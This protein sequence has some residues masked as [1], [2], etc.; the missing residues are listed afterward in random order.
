MDKL[1]S[2][3]APQYVDGLFVPSV[4]IPVS[5]PLTE[6]TVWDMLPTALAVARNP[7]E[8]FNAAQYKIPVS[9][10]PL[11]GVFFT[12]VNHPNMIRHCFVENRGNYGFQA[13]RQRVL[14]AIIGDGLI[15]AEGETWQHARR[16]MA[17]MFTPRAIKGFGQ[18]M[19]AATKRE[20]PDLFDTD[21]VMPIAPAMA[22]LILN[23]LLSIGDA[24]TAA[25][26]DTQIE[27]HLLAF[28]G[29]GHETTARALSWMFYLLS[30]DHS[31]RERLEA[32]VDALDIEAVSPEKWGEALPFATACFEETMRLFPPAPMIV[33]EAKDDDQYLTTHI[34]KKSV[35]MVNTWQLHRHET[36]WSAPNAFNPERFLG[37]NRAQIDR[38]QYLPFGVGERVCI[39][40]RFA[41]QEAL[42]LITL[43]ARRYRFD[44]AADDVP[45]PKM[46]ITVQPENHMPMRVTRR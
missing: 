17:P 25:F 24:E 22:T 23:R 32:E 19:R 28:I 29:A 13:L 14:R 11:F 36:L 27:D 42:I 16:A 33:R 6:Y 5:K 10:Y 20:I 41:M 37:D 34:P 45:W 30:N 18:I 26:T 31:A 46:R 3:P 39:G 4:P 8:T 7:L 44:Y 40:Q 21:A 38:F 9:Q 2:R 15:T 35:L 43:L 12:V 1:L